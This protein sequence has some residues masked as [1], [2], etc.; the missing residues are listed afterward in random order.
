MILKFDAKLCII[1]R[2]PKLILYIFM[3][4]YSKI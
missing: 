4:I 3:D 1:I 2:I